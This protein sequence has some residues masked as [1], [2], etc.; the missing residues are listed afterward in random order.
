[1]TLMT[2][3]V[4]FSFQQGKE[5]FSPSTVSRTVLGPIQPTIQWVPGDLTRR[6]KW[7]WHEGG[8]SPP[9]SLKFKNAWNY[10]STPPYVFMVVFL[11][12]Y[13]DN[14]TFTAEK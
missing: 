1:M 7:P 9:S 4:G 13:R 12:K 8:H 11:I 6:V 10:A 5:S 14:F 2:E 3:V